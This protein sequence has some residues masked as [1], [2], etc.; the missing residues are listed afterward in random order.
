MKTH[1]LRG[2][3]TLWYTVTLVVVLVL[4]GVDVLVVQQRFGL[5]RADRELETV[6]QTLGNLF[7]EELREL[8]DPMTAAREA[9][10]AIASLGDAVA[11]LDAQGAPLAAQLGGLSLAD[12]APRGAQP[13]LRT[14]RAGGNAWRVRAEPARF[15]TV[16]ATLVVARPLADLARERNEVREAMLVAIPLALLLAGAGGWWLA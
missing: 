13:A 7:R 15:G 14:V 16:N 10:A 5:R 12:L 4:F 8:D 2:R 9:C 6:N 11:I 3:L 1:S